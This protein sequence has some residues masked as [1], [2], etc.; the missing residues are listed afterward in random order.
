LLGTRKAPGPNGIPNEVVK[1]LALATRSALYYLLFLLA[2]K[3]YTPPEWCRN[4]TCL[5]R[6]QGDPTHLDNY[7]PIALMN[8]LLKLWTTL[9]KNAGSKYAETHGI[10]SDKHDGFRHHRSIH[11]VR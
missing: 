7:R 4:T 8:N 11:D 6:K 3:A 5:L 1:F 10:L 2:H 9:I